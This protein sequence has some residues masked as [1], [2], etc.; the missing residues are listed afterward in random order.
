MI[1]KESRLKGK[2]HNVHEV[3][4]EPPFFW[5]DDVEKACNFFLKYKDKPHLFC[6]EQFNVGFYYHKFRYY[7]SDES[8]G[9]VEYNEWL[10][11]LAF[12]DVFKEAMKK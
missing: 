11:K 2:I 4:G 5:K 6:M 12:A 7:V 1:N 10:F 3:E 8:F 9:R